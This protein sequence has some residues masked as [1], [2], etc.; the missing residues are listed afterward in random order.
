MFLWINWRQ[1]WNRSFSSRTL[2]CNQILKV[3]CFLHSSFTATGT[4][5]T[6]TWPNLL[7]RSVCF[8][9]AKPFKT[10]EKGDL[11]PQVC[12]SMFQQWVPVTESQQ[13]NQSQ[14]EWGSPTGSG[15]FSLDFSKT[16]EV[17]SA[18]TPTKCVQEVRRIKPNHF[19]FLP[20]QLTK[21]KEHG[22]LNPRPGKVSLLTVLTVLTGTFTLWVQALEQVQ[23]C[24]GPDRVWVQSGQVPLTAVKHGRQKTQITPRVNF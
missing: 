19:L 4:P 20:L 1:S 5:E 13:R 14:S 9:P 22:K 23:V 3:T 18:L 8:C 10:S 11:G 16:L 2:V 15:A 24:R 12:S 17:I 6:V 7:Q 21:E